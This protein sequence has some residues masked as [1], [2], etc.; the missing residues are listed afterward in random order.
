MRRVRQRD[1]DAEMALRR[2]LH[3]RGLRY[4]LHA[5]V[6]PSSRSRPDIIFRQAH[7]AVFVDG[8]FWH[9]CPEHGTE[10]KRNVDTWRRKIALNRARD[11]RT[12][13]Q[14]ENAGW[15][16]IRVWSHED[17]VEMATTIERIVRSRRAL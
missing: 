8:C 10:P 15:T 13:T 9:G 7:V 3:R 12:T 2:E 1:T 17:P 5:T 16:A 11:L 14:L 4:R 6:L